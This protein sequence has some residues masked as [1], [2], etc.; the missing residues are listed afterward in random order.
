MCYD[1]R[2]IRHFCIIKKAKKLMREKHQKAFPMIF[3]KCITVIPS[4]K[5]MQ[6]RESGQRD[7]DMGR[8]TPSRILDNERR[9]FAARSM[10]RWNDA[11]LPKAA[12]DIPTKGNANDSDATIRSV[13][14]ADEGAT[15][16][17]FVG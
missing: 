4:T 13:F 12:W 7:D 11:A 8:D 6:E 5:P 1:E 9:A 10:A 15:V 16:S 17:V 2:E 3:D 14:G